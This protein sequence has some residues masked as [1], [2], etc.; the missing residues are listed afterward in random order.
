MQDKFDILIDT[1]GEHYMNGYSLTAGD[2][3]RLIEEVNKKYSEQK[4]NVDPF[5][6]K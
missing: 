1:I 2:L 5:M 3:K 4:N 6:N